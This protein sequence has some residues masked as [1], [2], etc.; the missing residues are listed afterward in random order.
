[1]N[2]IKFLMDE[3]GHSYDRKVIA[4]MADLSQ[5]RLDIAIDALRAECDDAHCDHFRRDAKTCAKER[6]L[7]ALREIGELE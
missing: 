7:E 2:V 6:R 4:L 3:N 1:M 5:R